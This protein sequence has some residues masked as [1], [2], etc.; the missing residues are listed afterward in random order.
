[1]LYFNKE[2]EKRDSDATQMY[3]MINNLTTPIE[4]EHYIHSE[5]TTT[6]DADL[7][8]VFEEINEMRRSNIDETNVQLENNENDELDVT[9]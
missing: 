9:V 2:T 6:D 4:K 3:A 1:M 7:D 8:N 5:C